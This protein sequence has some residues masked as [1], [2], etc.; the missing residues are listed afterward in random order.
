MP[1][2]DGYALLY[3]RGADRKIGCRCGNQFALP[4]D[5][6]A[7]GPIVSARTLY[8]LESRGDCGGTC[9]R[10][11]DCAAIKP[12]RS[13]ESEGYKGCNCRQPVR[14]PWRRFKNALLTSARAPG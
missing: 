14:N 4:G 6:S 10:A 1:R 9:C 2:F 12:R 8:A 11:P 13:Q 7:D 3:P 5:H